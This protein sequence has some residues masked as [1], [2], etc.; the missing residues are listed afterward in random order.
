[1][2]CPGVDCEERKAEVDPVSPLNMPT[3]LGGYE[4]WRSTLNAAKLVVAPMVNMT[5]TVANTDFSRWTSQLCHGECC[6]EIMVRNFAI[7]QCSM[8]VFLQQNRLIGKK[9]L[10]LVQKT[11]L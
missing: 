7:H 9:S 6:P 10:P 5:D 8:H 2:V 4:F 3:K 1:M 11:V